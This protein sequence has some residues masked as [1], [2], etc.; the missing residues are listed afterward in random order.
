MTGERTVEI[1][2][3]PAREVVDPT[4]AGDAYRAGIVKGLTRGY[5]PERMGR[6]AA[7]AA[8]YCVENY[9]TMGYSY[10]PSE[11]AARF[12]ETFGES[13]EG[14]FSADKQATGLVF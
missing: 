3:A 1:P 9:G 2:P 11:F 12:S 5:T 8:T 6:I 4:G 10:T 14:I 13:A 7:L